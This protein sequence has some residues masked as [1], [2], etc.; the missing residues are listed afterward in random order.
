MRVVRPT[1]PAALTCGVAARFEDS[2]LNTFVDVHRFC[3]LPPLG[4]RGFTMRAFGHLG[5]ERYVRV[6]A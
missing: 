1:L 5:H 3:G 4:R 2:A 6:R